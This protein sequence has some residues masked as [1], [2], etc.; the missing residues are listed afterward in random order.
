MRK[1]PGGDLEDKFYSQTA[2]NALSG[3]QKD[4]LRQK[5]LDCCHVP[6]KKIGKEATEQDTSY[7]DQISALILRLD[8]LETADPDDDDT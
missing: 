6:T 4:T 1:A 3:E 2:C 8:A 7:G 5:H